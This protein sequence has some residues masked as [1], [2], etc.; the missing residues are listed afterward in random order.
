MDLLETGSQL[1]LP[2]IFVKKMDARG[3]IEPPI[4]VLQTP[5]LPLGYPATK[6]PRRSEGLSHLSSQEDYSEITWRICA[7]FLL[8]NAT[9]SQSFAFLCRRDLI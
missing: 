9:T 7:N 5:A 6:N 1:G 2:R 4:R 8:I 3:G